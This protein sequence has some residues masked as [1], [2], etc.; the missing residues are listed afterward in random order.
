MNVR[1]PKAD[2]ML[3]DYAALAELQASYATRDETLIR[4]RLEAW[5]RARQRRL[6]TS[7]A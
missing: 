7:V 4:S 5:A 6:E 2:A 1:S 3:E